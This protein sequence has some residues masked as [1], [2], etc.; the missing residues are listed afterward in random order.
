MVEEQRMTIT[1]THKQNGSCCSDEVGTSE[2]AFPFT[3][4][5]YS[6][7]YT[8]L[9]PL[10][11]FNFVFQPIP[12]YKQFLWV[13]LRIYFLQVF[14][15]FQDASSSL[16]STDVDFIIAECCSTN[17]PKTVDILFSHFDF[18]WVVFPVSFL[19][20]FFFFF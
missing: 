20:L 16:F 13:F 10:Q 18:V 19:A 8:F 15:M 2:A 11:F 6:Y 5:Y 12:F 17:W 9:L 4:F 3:F 7:P 1:L 14:F